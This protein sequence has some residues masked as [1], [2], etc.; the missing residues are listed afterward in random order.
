MTSWSTSYARSRDLSVAYSFGGEG[1]PRIV[2]VGNWLTNVE[3]F[4][5]VPA[6]ERYGESFSSMG[7]VAFLDQPGTGLSDP[8]ALDGSATLE[9]WSDS[10]RAV[11]D[12]LGWQD[13]AI[14]GYD[15]AAFAQIAFA[16]T[17]P[18]RTSA[19]V[20]VN[21]TARITTADD[22]PWGLPPDSV[23]GLLDAMM[24]GYGTSAWLKVMAPSVADDEHLCAL[25]ARWQRQAASP[26]TARGIFR[27]WH[28]TDVRSL[29]PLVQAPTLVLETDWPS[30]V[31]EHGAY[32]AEHIPQARLVDVPIPDHF[33]M[34]D[35]DLELL[36]GEIEEFLTGAR[37]QPEADRVLATV[38]FTD[39][40]DSTATAARLGD[41]RWRELLDRHDGAVRTQVERFHGRVVKTTGDG[42]LA[43]FDGPAKALRCALVLTS[44]LRE[45]GLEVRT[46]IHTGEIERRGEDVA[47]IGVVI[48]QRVQALAGSGQVL[49]SRTVTDLV[50]GSGLRFTDRGTHELKGV[51]GSW[52]VFE[53]E[54]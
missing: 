53:A 49:V 17:H 51:P 29:L 28:Q 3:A 20:V 10:I 40:V 16:A 50:A 9:T 34:R 21:A 8:M 26:A 1:P 22:Y 23:E 5:V 18:E 25:W 36:T 54:R 45:L 7:T 4:S 48:A 37:S 47:G 15:Q 11:M 52:N 30:R 46:G 13:A 44:S 39:I 38:L 19:L 12:D 42:V 24:E 33:P 41:R 31:H 2:H 27:M 14:V 43:T 32:L 35:D 6:I